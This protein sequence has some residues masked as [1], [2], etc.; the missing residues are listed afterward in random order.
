MKLD[1]QLRAE[2]FQDSK[3]SSLAR[4]EIQFHCCEVCCSIKETCFLTT[5]KIHCEKGHSQ[6]LDHFLCKPA[7]TIG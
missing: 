2:S 5:N 7:E 3:C 4:A 1:L 6:I